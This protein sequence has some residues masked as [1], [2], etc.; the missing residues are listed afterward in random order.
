M[1]LKSGKSKRGIVK[2]WRGSRT[3]LRSWEGWRGSRGPQGTN[4][5]EGTW[6]D[7][8]PVRGTGSRDATP[9]PA[10]RVPGHS[11]LALHFPSELVCVADRIRWKD[12]A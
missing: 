7:P 4:G 9:P 6:L 5:R 3:K 2:S 11:G 10:S 12:G 8:G 1:D